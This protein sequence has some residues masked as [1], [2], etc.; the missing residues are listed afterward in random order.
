MKRSRN[1]FCIRPSP[2]YVQSWCVH[3]QGN[4]ECMATVSI[5]HVAVPRKRECLQEIILKNLVHE[6]KSKLE[7]SEKQERGVAMTYCSRLKVKT[8]CEWDGLTEHGRT[9]D[10]PA[11]FDGGESVLEDIRCAKLCEAR[12]RPSASQP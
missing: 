12:K 5:A 10:D 3:Q 11:I 6:L 2:T 8:R 4:P 7:E 1:H 9:F